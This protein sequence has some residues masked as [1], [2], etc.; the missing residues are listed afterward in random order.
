M[1]MDPTAHPLLKTIYLLTVLGFTG[2]FVKQLHQRYQLLRLGQPLDRFRNPGKRLLGVLTWM[3]LQKRL[4]KRRFLAA[5]IMHATIFFGFLA[6]SLNTITFLVRGFYPQFH[7][8]F[9]GESSTAGQAYLLLKEIFSLFVLVMVGAAV[10]RRLVL[11]P[12]RLTLSPEAV[13]ILLLIALLML[14]DWTFTGA[15]LAFTQK[16][17]VSWLPFSSLVGKLVAPLGTTALKIIIQ[18][19]FWIHVFVL[20]IFLN[21]LPRSKHFH[22][23]TALF[24]VYFRNLESTPRLSTPD[25]ED[26]DLDHFGASKLTHFT[27]K[28]VLD[29]YSCTECGRC[30]EV[31]PAFNT[32]KPLSP[33][34]LNVAMRDALYQNGP[35]L[36]QGNGEE[37]SPL[38]GEVITDEVLWSCL[39]CKACEEVCPL[40]IEYIGRI[41]DMRRHLVLEES[42]MDTQTSLLFRNLENNGNPWGIGQSR[43]EEWCEDLKVPVFRR[44]KKADVLFWVGGA[45]AYDDTSRK[46]ARAMVEIFRAAGVDFA[47]LGQEETCTGDSARRLGNEYLYQM[48]AQGNIETLNQYEFREIVTICPHCL[49]TLGSEYPDLGGNWKVTHYAD[50][51]ARLLH[52]NRLKLE[53]SPELQQLTYHDSCYL[54]RHH[55][56]YA[57]PREVLQ[58]LPGV[59]LT[60][61]A[62]HHDDA[63]CCGAGGGRMW[64]EEESPR[65]NELRAK[66]ARETGSEAV[67]TACPFCATM[68]EDGLKDTDD[69]H[70]MRQVDLAVLVAESLSTKTGPPPAKNSNEAEGG[71]KE[72]RA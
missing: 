43:R 72:N 41:V 54:G 56:I 18:A 38:V 10:Y 59:Q 28:T 68:L 64:L 34:E 9:L 55:G 39:T 25:L 51:I 57:A 19:A 35:L 60:E 11:K 13:V 66:E 2:W 69:R 62:H 48:L 67:C 63:L 40:G 15:Q 46:T 22:V 3:F 61:M 23:V 36:L 32:Q 58:S 49:H 24:S 31:C 7:L 37:E 16:L 70:A 65:V 8:P 71:E 45:G 33:K 20:F 17:P 27:W 47:I 53:N 5:G 12:R 29:Y 1:V 14:A 52:E 6:V 21:L 26:E 50:F 4:F 30:Q 44:V 42:R